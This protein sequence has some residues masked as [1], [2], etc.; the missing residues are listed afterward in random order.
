MAW[1][2][3]NQ[4]ELKLHRMKIDLRGK[5]FKEAITC[6]FRKWIEEKLVYYKEM[7]DSMA[8][9]RNPDWNPLEGVFSRMVVDTLRG[10]ENEQSKAKNPN[11]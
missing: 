11:D 8:D 2:I 7:V 10:G 6:I 9:D 4:Y 3:N 5:D 1:I